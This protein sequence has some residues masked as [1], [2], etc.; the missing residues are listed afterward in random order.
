MLQPY[1]SSGLV[2]LLLETAPIAAEVDRDR[3]RSVLVREAR[4]GEERVLRAAWFLDATEL[5]DLL[6]MAGAEFVTGAEAHSETGEPHGRP[7]AKPDN[8]QAFTCC[9]AMSHHPGE[10]HTI[11][12]PDEYDFW[13]D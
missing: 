1:V 2:R 4:T 13:R 11:D 9:F 8:H 12:R 6:P 10:D 3:V 7:E 5:G